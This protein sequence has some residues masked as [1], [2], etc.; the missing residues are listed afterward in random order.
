MTISKASNRL[1][2]TSS[3]SKGL[4]DHRRP[5]LKSKVT[6]TTSGELSEELTAST[7][8]S[9]KGDEIDEQVVQLSNL[10]L[11]EEEQKEV[12]EE[13]HGHPI[14]KHA[15]GK[16]EAKQESNN[17][18]G[19]RK[20]AAAAAAASV[21]FSDNITMLNDV[22]PVIA[23]N[24][25]A[26][27]QDDDDDDKPV[28]F[29]SIWW[30]TEELLQ[31]EK[32]AWFMVKESQQYQEEVTCT[33]L[34]N[35]AFL[36]AQH[37][38]KTMNESELP[39][40]LLDVKI[41]AN[42]LESWAGVGNSRRGLEPMVSERGNAALD[43]NKLKVLKL[44][45]E[46][47][48]GL[49]GKLSAEEQANAIAKVSQEN[50]RSARIMAR[51]MGHADAESLATAERSAQE[52]LA[53]PEPPDFMLDEPDYHCYNSNYNNNNNKDNHRKHWHNVFKPIKKAFKRVFRPS[54]RHKQAKPHRRQN[55]GDRA[56]QEMR[57]RPSQDGSLIRKLEYGDMDMD[58]DL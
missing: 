41:H 23:T 30:T 16:K 55:H 21:R 51:M 57:Q 42:S 28:A 2:E 13:D 26:P 34:Y 54:L 10:S 43:N 35:K 48:K 33:V 4:P 32:N 25:G 44:Q 9:T 37:L 19:K 1:S 46:Q 45:Q 24:N 3:V 29:E 39:E 40:R 18:D 47:K 14:R 36:T 7:D 27:Q 52:V 12:D 31:I 5:S 8:I 11:L 6:T 20:T 56:S 58:S 17:D 50:S 15:E 53:L 38:A 22:A 49:H